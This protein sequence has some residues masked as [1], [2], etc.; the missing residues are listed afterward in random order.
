MGNNITFELD[1]DQ[2]PVASIKVAGVG[3]AG[4]NAIRRMIDNGLSR[5]EFIAVNTDEQVLHKSGATTQICIGAN[6]TRGLGAGGRPE[7]G[8]QALEE[9]RERVASALAG[10]DMVF[11]TAGM[12]GGTGT[13][14]SPVV[15][16]LAREIGALTVGVVTTP[17]IFEGRKRLSRAQ[18]GLAELRKNVDTLIVI[19]NQ[20]LLQVYPGK[21]PI[22]E[23]F[24]Q[25]DEVLRQAVQGITDIILVPGL[26]NLDF[27][28]VR[29]V[30]SHRGNATMGAGI[31]TGE[32][33][34][35]VSA[36]QA[37]HSPLLEDVSIE[38][39]RGVLV[40]ITSGPALSQDDITDAMEIINDSAGDDADTYFGVV[41]D[42]TVP[43]DEV[44]ITL[45][46]TGFEA[47]E[48]D[49][50]AQNTSASEPVAEEPKRV[51]EPKR[52]AAAQRPA[53]SNRIGPN[54][55]SELSTQPIDR[56][57]QSEPDD[58]VEEESQP[59]LDVVERPSE[60]VSATHD[61]I[62]VPTFIRK[63]RRRR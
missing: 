18:E 26:V 54:P 9:D 14:A 34:A 49:E 23:A 25:A 17:F 12:G 53:R 61:D 37:I 29:T 24:R 2:E 41:L 42:E 1:H 46:A 35:K 27:A 15:A 58:E 50:D 55:L 63:A 16:E 56:L 6:T 30:M 7:I 28:D 47:D 13:G 32:E 21:T 45:I 19:S 33:R 44:R 36:Q 57:I 39:A 59:T 3:G 20:R 51:E 40:N 48:T 38:G 22:N 11:I 31:G 8:R 10:A 60:P 52:Q 5:V 62:R 43:E 4:G